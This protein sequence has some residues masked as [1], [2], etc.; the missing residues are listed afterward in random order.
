MSSQEN[1]TTNNN[2]ASAIDI[3]LQ[4]IETHVKLRQ[5][6]EA[7]QFI[8]DTLPQVPRTDKAFNIIRS[9]KS[10]C[11]FFLRRYSECTKNSRDILED[12]FSNPSAR[13]YKVLCDYLRFRIDVENAVRLLEDTLRTLRKEKE[14]KM[15]DLLV[16]HLYLAR[17]ELAEDRV[18][19]AESHLDVLLDH[20]ILVA[21]VH[22]LEGHILVLQAKYEEAIASFDKELEWYEGR[23]LDDTQRDLFIQ[24]MIGKITCLS[25]L[26]NYEEVLRCVRVVEKKNP[27]DAADIELIV[28]HKLK[29]LSALGRV[30]ELDAVD[31]PK[32][33]KLKKTKN[34]M[35]YEETMRVFMGGQ[36]LRKFFIGGTLLMWLLVILL[37]FYLLQKRISR[38]DEEK[39]LPS[40]PPEQPQPVLVPAKVHT[41]EEY[42]DNQPVE[43][44]N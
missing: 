36:K 26:K 9:W 31:M 19:Q 5:Y 42:E 33:N 17:I 18:E 6:G 35:E 11:L 30:Q 20:P 39:E 1:N 10:A 40:P 12:E 44:E 43:E 27:V 41:E 29:A 32:L 8:E 15:F 37:A 23:L 24:A 38:K 25:E 21:G 16:N 34:R 3:Q 4:I 28:L 2:N 7:L 14:H 13:L 22:Q